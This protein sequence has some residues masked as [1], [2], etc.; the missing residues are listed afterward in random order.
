MINKKFAIFSD[1]RSGTSYLGAALNK[2]D[3]VENT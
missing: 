1:K 2:I 3:G